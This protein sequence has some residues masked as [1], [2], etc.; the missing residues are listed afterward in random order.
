[1]LLAPI[2]DSEEAIMEFVMDTREEHEREG[3][4]VRLTTTEDLPRPHR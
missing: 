3:F 1:M 2:P 4:W